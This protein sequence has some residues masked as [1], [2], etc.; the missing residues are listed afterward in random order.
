MNKHIKALFNAAKNGSDVEVAMF[1]RYARLIRDCNEH[2]TQEGLER[3]VKLDMQ[4]ASFT[5]CKDR[6][7][8][9]QK[10]MD[11]IK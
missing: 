2:V 11:I 8:A 7:S 3:L 5:P 6:Y 1:T 10:V 9:L 4:H